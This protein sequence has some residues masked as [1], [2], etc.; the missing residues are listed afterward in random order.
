MFTGGIADKLGNEYERKWAVRLTLEVIA[1]EADSIRYEGLPK[2]FVGF[3]LM[4]DRPNHTE[5]HQTKINAPHGNWTLTALIQEGVIDAFK[6]R[7][8]SNA[9]SKC[10][11]IS[12]GPS[13]QMQALCEEAQIANDVAEFWE[14]ISKKNRTAFDDLVK[15]WNIGKTTAFEWLQRCEFRTESKQS[16]EECINFYRWLSAEWRCRH[17]YSLI[18]LFVGKL[19]CVSNN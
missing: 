7:L 4:L 18:E 3:E 11:F 17:L 10:I 6:A 16:I 8:S 19:E 5:W 2:E 9:S 15:A 1:G 12:Q 14:A 13:A